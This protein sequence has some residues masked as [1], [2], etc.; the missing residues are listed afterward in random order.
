M[1]AMLGHAMGIKIKG[2][3]QSR[4]TGARS[5]LYFCSWFSRLLRGRASQGFRGW[6]ARMPRKPCRA[7]DGPSRRASQSREAQ[8]TGRRPATHQAGLFSGS[9]FFGHAK[10]MNT[11]G[12][13]FHT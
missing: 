9:V 6:A 3:R 13:Q 7:K 11:E 4:E 8:G 2:S 12:T 10:K 1:A 5:A